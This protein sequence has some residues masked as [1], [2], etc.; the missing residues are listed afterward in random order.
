MWRKLCGCVLCNQRLIV[1]HCTK[2]NAKEAK[3]VMFNLFYFHLFSF[4]GGGGRN[5][6]FLGNNPS[7]FNGMELLESRVLSNLSSTPPKPPG[8][9]DHVL[10]WFGNV[11]C[12]FILVFTN[13]LMSTVNFCRI[14]Q[15]QLEMY[16]KD[17][18]RRTHCSIPILFSQKHVVM[19]H[20]LIFVFE[21]T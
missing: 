1:Y 21:T 14:L 17:A 4:L 12:Q 11:F 2:G 3:Q 7:P 10:I 20:L 16:E 15:I 18:K 13:A 8:K 6:S 5:C 9:E 19:K